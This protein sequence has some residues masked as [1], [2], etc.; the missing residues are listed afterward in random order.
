MDYKESEDLTREHLDRAAKE[1]GVAWHQT[2]LIPGRMET[3][4]V[5]ESTFGTKPN[6]IHRP[7]NRPP[8]IGVAIAFGPNTFQ[9]GYAS[10]M[11]EPNHHRSIGRGRNDNVGIIKQFCD[12]FERMT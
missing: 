5:W 1:T 7:I 11:M 4:A 6:I 12:A 2:S 3:V 8:H 10:T 9:L